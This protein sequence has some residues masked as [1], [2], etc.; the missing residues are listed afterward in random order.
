MRGG[1]GAEKAGP[2]SGQSVYGQTVALQLTGRG[3]WIRRYSTTE[4]RCY[5]FT[6][7]DTAGRTHTRIES[8]GALGATPAST[9]GIFRLSHSPS[10]CRSFLQSVAVSFS[11]SHFPSVCR[12]FLQPVALSFS[13]S[14]FPSA[15]RTFLQLVA[16]SFSP[17]HEPTTATFHDLHISIL[18]KIGYFHSSVYEGFSILL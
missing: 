1:G 13:L 6:C 2:N 7:I 15:C 17:P 12:S 4:R 8:R 11:L 9:S 18:C 3:L 5:A 10:V 14:Q 16:L